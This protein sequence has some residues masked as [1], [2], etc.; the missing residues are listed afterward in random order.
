MKLLW[1]DLFRTTL[2]KTD[3]S[4]ELT[5]QMLDELFAPWPHV[6][7]MA[8]ILLTAAFTL[9]GGGGTYAGLAITVAVCHLLFR[10]AG[11]Q[12]YYR[13]ANRQN[14]KF[15]MNVFVWSALISGAA[16]GASI[17]LLL[18]GAT[19]SDR[20]LILTVACVIIQSA[21][22]R[23]FMAPLPLIGQ[24]SLLIIQIV[25]V[26]LYHGDWIIAPA[27]ILFAGFQLGHMRSLIRFRLRQLQAE[28]EKDAL[29]QQVARTNEDL[30]VANELLHKTALTDVLTGLPNRRA[31]DRWMEAHDPRRDPRLTP[32]SLILF[33]VDHFKPFNDTHGHQAG[34]TCLAAIG[35]ALRALPLPQDHLVARYGGEEFVVILPRTDGQTAIGL[36]ENI[37]QKL[38]AIEIQASGSSARITASLG[39]ATL[40]AGATDDR[41]RLLMKADTALYRAK[42]LG[43]NRVEH[44]DPDLVMA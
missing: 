37:R 31:L 36:A 44:E 2:F 7:A 40:A 20:Y 39:V 34:D 15:W 38:A 19:P 4:G 3:A 16:W 5:W 11:G 27:A 13:R 18:H 29:L 22:A 6:I 35:D 14:P 26:G 25:G 43:R 23:A 33:D 8:G 17:M 1:S 32:Y 28:A 24:T 9:W 41:S 30:R 42:Q 12:W 10:W 21:T